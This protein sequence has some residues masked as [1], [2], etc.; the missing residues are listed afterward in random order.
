M[1]LPHPDSLACSA[2][3]AKYLPRRG[4]YCRGN[5]T[6]R[7]CRCS[8]LNCSCPAE[9]P[10]LFRDLKGVC[11]EPVLVNL[12][13]SSEDGASKGA[14]FSHHFVVRGLCLDVAVNLTCVHLNFSDGNASGLWEGKVFHEHSDLPRQAQDKTVICQDRLRTKRIGNWISYLMVQAHRSQ[15][16]TRHCKAKKR[17]FKTIYIYK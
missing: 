10:P 1:R 17:S 2:T 5:L 13:F 9:T 6:G 16:S 4:R 3:I 11:P 15:R 8:S 12:C 14:F 7:N